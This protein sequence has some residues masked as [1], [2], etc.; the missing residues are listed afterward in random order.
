MIRNSMDQG[1]PK[2]QRPVMNGSIEV[3]EGGYLGSDSPSSPSSY[4][5]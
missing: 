2:I 1:F 5:L 3:M 4:R